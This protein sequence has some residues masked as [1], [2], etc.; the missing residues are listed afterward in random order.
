ML[1]LRGEIK[2]WGLL[3]EEEGKAGGKIAKV[4]NPTWLQDSVGNREQRKAG[5]LA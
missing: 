2:R 4:W 3:M 1:C 5:T